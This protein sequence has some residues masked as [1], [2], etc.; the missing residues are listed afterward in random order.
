MDGQQ[1][2]PTEF[3][4]TSLSAQSDF[5]G[6]QW[7][8]LNS[9]FFAGQT[10]PITIAAALGLNGQKIYVWQDQD[11]VLVV[12]TK[13]AHNANQGYVLSD[14]NLPDTCTARNTCPTSTGDE[15]AAF[16]QLQ[17]MTL[18]QALVE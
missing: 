3:V 15:V 1:I 5:Y 11:I 16:D 6:L 2:V 10:P 8:I 18:L 7:W 13:Y 4:T 9:A 12:Q 14:T 17:L